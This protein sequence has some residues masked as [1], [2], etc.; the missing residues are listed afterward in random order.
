MAS[1]SRY[2]KSPKVADK[3][4]KRPEMGAGHADK[5]EME[6]KATASKEKTPH[7]KS[8]EMKEGDGKDSVAPSSLAPTGMEESGIPVH[9]RHAMERSEL[10]HRQMAEHHE[11]HHRHERE[12]MSGDMEAE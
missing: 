2:G 8:K 7:A 5:A 4:M 12:R 11:M 10:H 6:E 3:E 9:A 1:K